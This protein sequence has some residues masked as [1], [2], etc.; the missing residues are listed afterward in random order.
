[1]TAKNVHRD[2]IVEELGRWSVDIIGNGNGGRHAY[3]EARLPNGARCKFH[4]SNTRSSENGRLDNVLLTVRKKLRTLG[5]PLRK[6]TLPE[7]PKM[8]EDT[9]RPHGHPLGAQPMKTI[10]IKQVEATPQEEEEE[11]MTEMAEIKKRHVTMTRTES[12]LIMR[13]VTQESFTGEDKFVRYKEGWT[14]ARVAEVVTE[15]CKSSP[16]ITADQVKAERKRTFID[17]LPDPK[18]TKPAGGNFGKMLID[19][20][21]RVELLE[22]VVQSLEARLNKL[23]HKTERPADIGKQEQPAWRPREMPS[24]VR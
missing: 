17:W 21:E 4:H 14:D 8:A 18:A 16:P 23:E 9:E 2:L 15:A 22:Q 1:M 11:T 24:H 6:L 7:S 12:N 13:I 5:V 20:R 3:V 10:T 19:A